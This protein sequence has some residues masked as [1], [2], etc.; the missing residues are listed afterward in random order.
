MPKG[1]TDNTTKTTEITMKVVKLLTPLDS[2]GRRKAIKASLTLLGEGPIEL[3]A[4]AAGI[5][6]NG[7]GG[8]KH[9]AGMLGLSGKA[10]TWVKQNGL[11][12]DQLEQ[13]F[14]IDGANT[15]VIADNIPG[16]NSKEQT[17][18]AYVVQG[19]A[20]LVATGEP[21]FD[22]KSARK[23]CEDLGCYNSANHAVYIGSI[24]NSVTGSKE[25]GW[26]L[27]APGLKKGAELV[28]EMTKE[29]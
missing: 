29:A 11:T 18:A 10:A 4:S 1:N 7:D 28:K 14:D 21:T 24:G 27:T 2:E 26:K 23:L 25:K 17:I 3:D 15:T 16:K 12:K 20:K 6:A 13:V 8:A 5:A 19:I 9:G 22:D